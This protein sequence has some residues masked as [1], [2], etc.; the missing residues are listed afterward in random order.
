MITFISLRGWQ[1]QRKTAYFV[2]YPLWSN[3][4]KYAVVEVMKD[5]SAKPYPQ[6]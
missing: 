4:Y 6:P 5:G 1:Y 3:I 2:T